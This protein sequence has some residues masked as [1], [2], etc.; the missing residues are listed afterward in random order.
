[1][2][3]PY[4]SEGVSEGGPSLV[5]VL[6]PGVDTTTEALASLIVTE[7]GPVAVQAGTGALT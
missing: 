1:M 5:C 3:H 2:A 7:E 4:V 6:D